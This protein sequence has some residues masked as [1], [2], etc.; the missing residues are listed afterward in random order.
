MKNNFFSGHQSNY[1]KSKSKESSREK[2]EERWNLI[3]KKE[4]KVSYQKKPKIILRKSDAVS[5][6]ISKM[7]NNIQILAKVLE[8]TLQETKKQTLALEDIAA[9]LK[10]TLDNKMSSKVKV[11]VTTPLPSKIDSKNLPQKPTQIEEGLGEKNSK[12]LYE[13]V[14]VLRKKYTWK[15]IAI[16]LNSKNVPTLSGTS[17]WGPELLRYFMKKMTA[18]QK[19]YDS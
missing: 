9:V 4:P 5:E 2:I 11:A 16:L 18:H 12:K 1:T 19:K 14:K 8:A 7:Q 3:T 17:V 15:N 10:R 6:K 13:K